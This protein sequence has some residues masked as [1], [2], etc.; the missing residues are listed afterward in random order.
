MKIEELKILESQ[1]ANIIDEH[2]ELI[3][4]TAKSIANAKENS[5]KFLIVQSVLST[6]LKTIEDDIS[7]AITIKEASYAQAI[8]EVGGSKIT[9]KKIEVATNVA[10]TD[11]REFYE[12]LESLKS[13]IKTH[14]KIFENGHILYRQY[15]N[16]R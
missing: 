2:L 9:E 11:S 6:I 14:I 7:K 5:A 12:H 1:I 15:G 4:V 10:Y 8:N 16:D 3:T 13:W